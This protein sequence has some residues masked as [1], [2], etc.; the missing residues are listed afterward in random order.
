MEWAV[1]WTV[2]IEC[3]IRKYTQKDL[4]IIILRRVIVSCFAWK[5]NEDQKNYLHRLLRIGI[6]NHHVEIISLTQF[7]YQN[8]YKN[9]IHLSILDRNVVVVFFVSLSLQAVTTWFICYYD[10][11][12]SQKA[13]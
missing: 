3:E 6:L 4:L 9:A 2:Q 10:K 8:V 1:S 11:P 5:N 7:H 12:V 13:A